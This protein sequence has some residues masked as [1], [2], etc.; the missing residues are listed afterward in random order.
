MADDNN[1]GAAPSTGDDKPKGGYTFCKWN[2]SY[3]SDA[4]F[5]VRNNSTGEQSMFTPGRTSDLVW[6]KSKLDEA[7]EMSNWQPFGD[8]TVPDLEPIA[9]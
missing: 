2:G 5:V 9:F 1:M 4:K 8:E 6:T 3:G 7:P